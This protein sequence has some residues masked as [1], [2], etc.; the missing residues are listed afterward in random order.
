MSFRVALRRAASVGSMT[1]QR[2]RPAARCS[3]I[4][5]PVQQARARVASQGVRRL[6]QRPLQCVLTRAQQ[7]CSIWG[8][9]CGDGLMFLGEEDDG[10]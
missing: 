1:L 9:A 5:A 3:S 6:A 8:Q 4:G 7:Q 2:S 10:T